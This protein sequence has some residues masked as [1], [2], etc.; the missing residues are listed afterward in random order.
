MRHI[1]GLAAIVLLVVLTYAF[2]GSSPAVAPAAAPDAYMA[3]M[4]AAVTPTP[5]PSEGASAPAT[6]NLSASTGNQLEE[7]NPQ[8]FDHPTAISN[9]WFPLRP[10]TQFTYEGFTDQDGQLIP[11]RVVFSVTDLTKV[12]DNVRTVVIYDQDFKNNQVE[13]LELTF[14]AQDNE[15]NVWHLGQYR[16]EYTGEELA[17]S[18]AWLVGALEGAKAGIMMKAAPKLGMPSYSEGFAPAPF[19]WTDR[20]RVRQIGQKTGVPFANYDDV[21]VI[22]ESSQKETDAF[23]L[24]Y[25]ARHV[26]VVRVGWRGND[27]S[28]ETLE[29]VNLE[30]LNPDAMSQIRAQALQMEN[31]AYVYGHTLPAE[32]AK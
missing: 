9:E 15:G 4:A 17:G 7:I 21:L 6:T 10:G 3:V 13:E 32:Q 18:Q 25:Y 11:H 29:L 20:G 12:I 24:K 26:G 2:G 23:Q 31:R 5:A 28:K 8:N 27:L 30:Q 14:F 19:N 22:E 1:M 16:E